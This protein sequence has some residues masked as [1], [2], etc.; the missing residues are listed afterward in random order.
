MKIR[1]YL[2]ELLADCVRSTRALAAAKNIR[3]ELQS[4]PDLL[5]EADEALIRRMFLNLIDN[6]IKFTPATAR[7]ALTARR[8][9]TEYRI[10][11]HRF[12][13]RHSRRDNDRASFERFFRA[14]QARTHPTMRRR[15]P[16]SAWQSHA[17]S[18]RA[19]DGT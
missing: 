16:D 19:H 2:D 12:G 7:V 15:A 13:C 5:I 14:D 8:D 6:A 3:L 18:P 17:G 1:F 4:E 10:I 9:G 11:D